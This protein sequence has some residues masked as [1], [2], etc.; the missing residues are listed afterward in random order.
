MVFLD[1]RTSNPYYNAETNDWDSNV[2]IGAV[3]FLTIIFV[4]RLPENSDTEKKTTPLS[5]K[6][7]YLD[8]PGGISIIGSV[9][10]LILALQWGGTTIPWRSARIVGLFVG[11]GLL[12]IVFGLIQ[13]FSQEKATIPLR[14]LR[15][16]SVI[17]GACFLFFLEM[18]IYV[19][20][21]YRPATQTYDNNT[22]RISIISRF[23]F[24]RSREFL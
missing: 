7:R 14:L 20:R 4:L 22:S 18:S 2:P 8:I 6:Y 10:C 21:K 16:R 3:T 5:E 1:V 17:T 12:L 23:I 24:R 15:Q 9:C 19:V 11:F 13:W